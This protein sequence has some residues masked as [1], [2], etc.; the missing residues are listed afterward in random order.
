M[1]PVQDSRQLSFGDSILALL[2]KV[3]CRPLSGESERREVFRLRYEAYRR[4]GALPAGTPTEF[5]D[6][7]D[8]E[9]NTALFGFYIDGALASSMRLHVVDAETPATPS[10]NTF[11][12]HLRP[13]IEGGQILIDPTRFVVEAAAARKHP[14]L[15]YVTV[16]LAWMACEWFGSD[17]LLATV[18]SEHQAFYNRLFGHRVLCAARP[19]PTLTKPLS[20]MALDYRHERDRV[21]TRYPFFQSTPSERRRLFGG[22][23]KVTPNVLAQAVALVA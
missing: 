12:D 7:F 22:W 18:R 19:Y 16:R 3:E 5:R 8:D 1:V 23:G 10:M 17:Q 9:E 11:P 20:L 15:P 14:K 13:M 4:E 21:M 2:G 6:R